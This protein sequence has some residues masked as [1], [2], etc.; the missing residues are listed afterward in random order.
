MAI[1]YYSRGLARSNKEEYG[2]A[3]VD[4]DEA[5]RIDP[6]YAWSHNLRGWLL[7][8]KLNDE[9]SALADYN[10]AIRLDPKLAGAYINRGFLWRNRAE[11]ARALADFDAAIL[12]EPRNAYARYQR[13]I[14]LLAMRRDGAA[15]EARAVL[16]IQGWRGDLSPY[17]VLMEH[18][19]LRRAGRPDQARSLLDEAAGKCDPT[20]W[21]YPILKHLRGELDEDKLLAAAEDDDK[22]IEA[23]C[24]LGLEA[25]EDGRAGAALGHFRWVRDQDHARGPQVMIS[26][27][28]LERLL[29]KGAE[30]DGP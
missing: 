5:I 18:F 2:R 4:Y 17:A 30:G 9:E 3:V 25:V 20:A 27:A 13:G 8:C 19:A 6:S 22:R 24:Y 15:D 29:A 16:D 7:Q 12:L 1:A 21:P 28:E 14:V 10:E 26:L 11:W 23:R